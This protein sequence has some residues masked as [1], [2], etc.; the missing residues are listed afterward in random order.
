MLIKIKNLK[1]HTNLGVYTWEKTFN[2]EIIINAQIET[3]FNRSLE[4]DEIADTI[5]YDI[6]TAKIKNLVAQNRFK[7][8]EKL[9]QQMMD[10]IMQDQRIKSCKL[11]IDKVGV[12]EAVESFSV[13]IEETRKNGH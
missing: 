8:I 9:A 3:D 4:S 6:I 12:V 10:E 5:D 2:R 1:L 7:L 11:E 13:T